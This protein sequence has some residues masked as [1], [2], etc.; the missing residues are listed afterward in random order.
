MVKMQERHIVVEGGISYCEGCMHRPV[1]EGCGV[2][3]TPKD[4]TLHYLKFEKNIII[5]FTLDDKNAR[6]SHCCGGGN[7]ISNHP[8][9]S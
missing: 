4:N 9:R 5:M 6:T 3:K 7:H 2:L 8:K 1:T